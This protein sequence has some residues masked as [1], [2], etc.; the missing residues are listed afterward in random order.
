MLISSP[1]INVL[2][3]RLAKSYNID[4]NDPKVA[5]W[6]DKAKK[7]QYQEGDYDLQIVNDNLEDSYS[8][9]REYCLSLYWKYFD[10]EE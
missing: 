2:Q 10:E 8:K 9:L 4:I 7:G 3:E 1:S 5:Q 6:V